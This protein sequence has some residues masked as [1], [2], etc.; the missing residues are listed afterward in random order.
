MLGAGSAFWIFPQD[1]RIRVYIQTLDGTYG[2]K[3]PPEVFFL[4]I[5]EASHQQTLTK[6]LFFTPE[7][8]F[9]NNHDMNH[10]D[11][12]YSAYFKEPPSFQ[13]KRPTNPYVQNPYVQ[14]VKF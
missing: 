14:N 7:Y 10:Y 8:Q 9:K 3:I 4:E 12:H 11:H 6:K 5:Y 13:F 2:R 1:L